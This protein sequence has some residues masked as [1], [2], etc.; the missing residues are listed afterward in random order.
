MAIV[1]ITEAS[2][3]T[4]KSTATLHRHIK[5]GKLSRTPEGKLDTA[6]LLRVYGAFKGADTSQSYQSAAAMSAH[7]TSREEWL[8]NQIEKLQNDIKEL[9]QE[10]LERERRL[11]ALIEHKVVS[12][13]S[14]K[15]GPSD[16]GGIFSR[17]FK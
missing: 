5:A 8:M 12:A 13:G 4:G 2:R 14:S 9:K 15:D 7:E 16:S 1:T 10:S 11:L 17:L 6:E 3:L